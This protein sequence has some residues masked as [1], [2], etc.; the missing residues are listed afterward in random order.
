MAPVT[1]ARDGARS[2]ESIRQNH[3]NFVGRI[4][5]GFHP[6]EVGLV[7]VSKTC[8]TRSGRAVRAFVCLHL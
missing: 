8:L 5:F 4:V 7:V 2:L 1:H 6:C 3:F